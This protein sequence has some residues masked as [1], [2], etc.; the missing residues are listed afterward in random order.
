MRLYRIYHKACS[1]LVTA[2]TTFS[3]LRIQRSDDRNSQKS[4]NKNRTLKLAAAIS[5]PNGGP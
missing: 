2:D 4:F 5:I 3:N 1:I